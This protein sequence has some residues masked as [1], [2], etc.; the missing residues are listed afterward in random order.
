M[1]QVWCL[2]DLGW[3]SYR[4]YYA[5]GNL[6]FDDVAT[7]VIFGVFDA[8]RV[9]SSDP[10]INSSNILI[11]AD[12]R[13]SY[14]KSFFPGYKEKRHDTKEVSPDELQKLAEMKKQVHVL[15][16]EILPSIGIPVYKQNGCESDDLMAMAA[17]SF[18]GDEKEAVIVTADGDLYQ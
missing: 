10:Q 4:A 13:Q 12:S 2:C 17:R 6:G 5:T 15:R 11:F 1:K 8:L 3:L 18:K 14:R 9:L 7:G 16:E